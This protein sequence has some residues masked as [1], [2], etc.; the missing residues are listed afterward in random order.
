MNL[1]VGGFDRIIGNALAPIGRL[2]G[3]NET[4]IVAGLDTLK[5]GP[6]TVMPRRQVYADTTHFIFRDAHRHDPHAVGA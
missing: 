5:I 3:L 6:G 4:V 1:E 2:E